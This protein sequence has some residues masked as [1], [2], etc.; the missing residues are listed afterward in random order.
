VFRFHLTRPPVVTPVRAPIDRT[1]MRSSSMAP[2]RPRPV[3]ADELKVG[4]VVG[5][6]AGE[7]G[8]NIEDAVYKTSSDAEASAALP[9][10]ARR[11]S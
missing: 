11:S 10:T 1:M 2:G 3:P 4:G 8:E 5:F 7:F 6:F 9:S